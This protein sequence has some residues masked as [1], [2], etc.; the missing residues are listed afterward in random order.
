MVRVL[1]WLVAIPL[2]AVTGL[3]AWSWWRERGFNGD[4][5]PPGKL[6]G[7]ATERYLPHAIDAL[8]AEP[9]VIFI[10]GNPGTS[11]DFSTVM[12]KLSPKLRTLSFDRPGYGW[13]PRP[14]PLMGPT[15]QAR[16]IHGAVKH[17]GIRRP[18]IA[19][20]SYGG[21][22]ALAYALEFP[23]EVSALVLIAAVGSPEEKHELGEAQAKLLAPAGPLIAWGLGPILGPD[24]V[25]EGYVEAFSP[26]PVD[27]ALVE[28]GRYHFTRPPTLLASAR[29]W[30]LLEAELPKLAERYGELDLPVEILSANQDKIVSQRHA[31][32]LAAHLKGS[33]RADVDGAGHQLMSTHTQAVV[34]AVLRAVARAKP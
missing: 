30:K 33:R 11:L 12:E 32:Y 16:F 10:H 21:A 24:A 19:G 28:R 26:N 27:E 22:V 13:S 23:S 14:S 7:K 18:V 6:I 5:P 20:F 2:A 25:T 15:E 3:F 29:D 1:V 9:T 31:A 8:G 4:H 34:D 17:L